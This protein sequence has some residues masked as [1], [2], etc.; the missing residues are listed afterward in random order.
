MPM[1]HI[2]YLRAYFNYEPL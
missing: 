1:T 2:L